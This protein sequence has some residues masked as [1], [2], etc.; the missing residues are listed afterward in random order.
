M[1]IC[2][3]KYVRVPYRSRNKNCAGP[4]QCRS[5]GS[6]SDV[7]CPNEYVIEILNERMTSFGLD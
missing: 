7:N 2:T 6:L 5:D 3:K 1:T 4:K